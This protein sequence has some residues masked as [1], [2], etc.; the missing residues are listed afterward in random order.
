MRPNIQRLRDPER[1]TPFLDIDLDLVEGTYNRLSTALPGIRVRY[2]V[3]ANP[4]PEIIA[5]LAGQ[6]CELGVATPGETRACLAAGVRGSDLV[7]LNPVRPSAD[8]DHA[9]RSGIRTYVVDSEQEVQRL[10]AHAPGAR[11]LVRLAHGEGDGADRPGSGKF[12]VSPTQAVQLAVN[13]ADEGLD[14]LGLTWHMGDQQRDLGEWDRSLSR[15]ASVTHT[16][17]NHGLVMRAL[18]L[19]GGLPGSYRVAAP[20]M[21]SYAAAIKDGVRRHFR[22]GGPQVSLQIGRGLV[23]DSGVIV[24]TVNGTAL[25]PDGRRWV[26]LDAGH[27]NAALWDV[28]GEAIQ[29]RVSSLEHPPGAAMGPA[30]LAGP[31]YDES[32]VLYERVPYELPLD[33]AQ[34]D[35]V[36][37]WSAGAYTA[38]DAAACAGPPMTFSTD[39]SLPSRLDLDGRSGSASSALA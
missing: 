33:L 31:S 39:G 20:S 6:G 7:H 38:R 25:R 4:A 13:A 26:F 24:A 22:V 23:A 37:F 19:G 36:A 28:R 9:W 18:H 5:T 14:V 15:A 12:G 29:F 1:T 17:A 21:A 16:L 34:G 8:I 3:A 27:H 11:I 35:R 2:T 10:G 30:V 32:D